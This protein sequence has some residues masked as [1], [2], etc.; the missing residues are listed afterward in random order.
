MNVITLESSLFYLALSMLVYFNCKLAEKYRHK[1]FV[2]I[3][4]IALSLVAG[5]R[6]YSVGRDTYEYVAMFNR[7]YGGGEFNKD[8][9]F[10]LICRGIMALIPS[11]TFVFLVFAVITYGCIVFRFWELRNISSFT[12]GVMMFFSFYFF[13]SMNICRQFVAVA[14][15]FFSTRYLQKKKY[16]AYIV[17]IIIAYFFHFSAVLGLVCFVS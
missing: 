14:I 2:F 6:A 17:G 12:Y 4:V 13:E 9:I 1:L 7:F 8:P 15:V 16:I 10:A 11:P 5:F 3:I